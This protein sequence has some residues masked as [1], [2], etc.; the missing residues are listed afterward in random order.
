MQQQAQR[1]TPE[2]VTSYERTGEALATWT[3]ASAELLEL[4]YQEIFLKS[5]QMVGHVCD[6]PNA[7]DFLTFDLWRDSR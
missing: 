5:W 6:L 3:Y 2:L 1:H 4:E 7:G